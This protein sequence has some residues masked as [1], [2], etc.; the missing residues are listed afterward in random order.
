MPGGNNTI[1]IYRPLT[2]NPATKYNSILNLPHTPTSLLCMRSQHRSRP[3]GNQTERLNAGT[4]FLFYTLAS[5]L[6]LLVA[7]LLLQNDTGSL[8]LLTLPYTKTIHLHTYAD[9][10]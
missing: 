2:L 8:S 5:S 6:P 10:L 4:Y 9:K 1:P 7:L 3:S